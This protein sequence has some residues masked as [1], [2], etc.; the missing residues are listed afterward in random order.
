MQLSLYGLVR[1]LIPATLL[2]LWS[3]AN[4]AGTPYLLLS[5]RSKQF[6]LL[7]LM[8]VLGLTFLWQLIAGSTW[9]NSGKWIRN[10]AI[11]NL[12]AA[13]CCSGI[14][15]A[16]CNVLHSLND[17]LQLAF[18][19]LIASGTL[20]LL[21]VAAASTSRWLFINF[22]FSKRDV[23]LIGSGPRAQILFAKLRESSTYRIAGVVDD[24]FV[25]TPE[26]YD[27]YL[28]GIPDLERILK[29]HPVQ[30]VY[31]SLPIRS[32]Y[33]QAQLATSICSRIGV[34]VLHSPELFV[35]PFAQVDSHVTV[36]SKFTILRT[37]RQ[38]STRLF[39]RAIDF[40]GALLLLII[41]APL[42]VA[43]ALAIKLTSP[44]PIFFS[45]ER[46]GLNRRRFRVFKLRTMVVNAEH[47][48]VR[49]ESMNELDG[50]VFKI[51]RD[52]RVTPVGRW[53]RKSS[54]DELPQLWN[55]LMGD[56]SLV[57]PRP[58]AVRDFRRIDD[59]GHLRRFSVKPGITCL[60][61]IS[62]RNNTTFKEW[63]QQDLDYID[64]WSLL[65]DA[66]ILLRTIPTVLS[67]RGAM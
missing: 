5:H 8:I 54:I 1:D 24:K 49:Y 29:E 40:S 53:L 41:T 58:L 7:D 47:L 21:V 60:W 38:D 39:K 11:G 37:V 61:Q 28:G 30:A 65:L 9:A 27:K 51:R 13:F 16:M 26:M 43:G 36:D 42:V 3:F 15:F 17:S 32:M 6:S 57:G 18:L 14:V 45:Q 34:E 62:G 64:R 55:V 35:A 44:G 31:C 10:Q 56:M 48:Q 19:F 33:D 20:G 12:L 25:G 2:A 23:I 63:I 59:S 4:H 22:I 50:P 52:P 67:G 66:A 46:C